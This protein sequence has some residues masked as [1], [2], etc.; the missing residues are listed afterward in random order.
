MGEK[1]HP[2]DQ[3]TGREEK[4][5][6][7]G[8]EKGFGEELGGFRD[9]HELIL[10]SSSFGEER[11]VGLGFP[12]PFL[13]RGYESEGEDRRDRRIPWEKERERERD[14]LHHRHTPG[15]PSPRSPSKM[16]KFPSSQEGKKKKKKKT[17]TPLARKDGTKQRHF[18]Q[19]A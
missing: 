1:S 7:G 17:P 13:S 18:F 19:D 15:Y 10:S 2:E 3:T 11:K 12:C 4:D 14:K 9:A 16:F 6:E 8:D 5:E